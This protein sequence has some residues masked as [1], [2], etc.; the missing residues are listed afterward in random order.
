MERLTIKAPS[1]LIHL[2]DNAETTINTAINKLAEYEDLE[3]IF[4]SKMTDSACEIL[5]D[6][7][8]FAKWLD[9]NKWIAKK[10]NE[11]ARA[12]E[13]GK[14]LKL[15]CAVGDKIYIIDTDDR[16]QEKKIEI[17]VIDNIVI[18]ND[19]TIL[20]MR[21]PYEDVICELENI[22]TDKPYLGFYKCFLSQ[23]E[24]EAA[25][26]ELCNTQ[27]GADDGW[28]EEVPLIGVEMLD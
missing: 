2:K 19:R 4:R 6:K 26:K 17:C 27:L 8:E 5:K 10:C 14:L 11:N 13:Q 12:E 20:F 1:G 23:E 18:T 28:P 24:A 22:I 21:D 25:L 3:E 7:E 15:P 16:L 9:R